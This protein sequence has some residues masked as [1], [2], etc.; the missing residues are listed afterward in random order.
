MIDRGELQDAAR[1]AFGE[2]GLAPDAAKSWGL[3]AEMGW[4]MMAVPEAQGGLGLGREAEGVIHSEIG[5]ALVPGPVIAQM[6]VITA[7]AA[8]GQDDFLARA[9]GGEVMTT[10]LA[11][12][13]PLSAIPDG[14]KASHVLVVR[15]DAIMLHPVASFTQRPTWDE[16]RR[17]FDI[18]VADD[19]ALVIAQ[20]EAATKLAVRLQSQL[21]FALAG[22]SL[23]GADAILN[24]TIDYLKT[25]RQFDRPLAMFQALK[26]RVADLKTILTAAEALFWASADAHSTLTDIGAL[27]AHACRVYAEVAEE[28]IQL[29]GGIGLT[30]EYQCHLFLKRAMLNAALGGDADHWEEQ[31]GRQALERAV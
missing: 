25:R 27:K 5:R 24:L 3:I 4:L 9:M 1:K 29:H 30:S 31:V 6:L 15:D 17:L 20:G 18:T 22:D 28:A 13:D 23:G 12:D 10:S 11:A 16:T 8:T 2:A 19:N 7:L 14:D 21:L 26:H